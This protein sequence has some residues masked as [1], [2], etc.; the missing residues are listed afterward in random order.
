MYVIYEYGVGNMFKLIKVLLVLIIVLIVI[1]CI[2][3][4]GNDRFTVIEVFNKI[5]IIDWRK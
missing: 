5:L 3:I 2:F 1:K 4:T